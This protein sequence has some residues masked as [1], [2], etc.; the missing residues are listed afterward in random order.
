MSKDHGPPGGPELLRVRGITKAFGTVL[1]NDDIS[2]DLRAGE[3][4]ALLGENG[5]GKSTLMKILYG[6]HPPDRGTLFIQGTE[7]RI[8]SP[9][10]A[11]DLGIGMV[12][13]HFALV[14]TFTAAQNVVLGLRP[15][16]TPFLDLDTARRRLQRLTE[17]YGLG[18][19]LVATIDQL[20]IGDQQRLEIVKSLFREVRILLLDEPTAVL[21]PG[22]GAGPLSTHPEATPG[23][24]GH[25]VHLAQTG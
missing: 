3:V 15:R 17:E 6:L 8:P 11:M 2:L 12:H 18:V 14:P 24:A 10:R 25:R 19:D 21:A 7:V 5:A 23:R 4:H 22:G 16:R 20:S 1:A 9:R 13:Q